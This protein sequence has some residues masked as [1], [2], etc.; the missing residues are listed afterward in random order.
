MNKYIK[1]N[2]CKNKIGYKLLKD[3]EKKH[4]NV[5]TRFKNSVSIVN[6][7]DNHSGEFTTNI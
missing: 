5:M 3:F 1:N 7:Q 6:C 4:L 2:I